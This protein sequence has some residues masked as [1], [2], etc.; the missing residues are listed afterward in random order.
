MTRLVP[1]VL[2]VLAWPASAQ[3]V[4]PV[5][6]AAPKETAAPAARP[7]PEEREEA[8]APEAEAGSAADAGA[9]DGGPTD[10]GPTDTGPTD[11]LTERPPLPTELAETPEDYRACLAALD[12]FG[13]EYAEREAIEGAERDCGIANPVG[14][15]SIVPGV[16]L[17]PDAVMRCETALALAQWV[18]GTVVPAARLAG[19]L[20]PLEAVDHGSTYV[21]RRR[22]GVAAGKLSEHALGNAVDVMGFRFADGTALSVEPRADSGTIEEAFQRAVRGGACLSFTTVLGPGTDAAHADHLHLDVKKRRAGYRIC[23]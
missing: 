13:T 7:D 4:T 5:G 12:E 19:T 22:G 6:E 2:I 20:A 23:Q 9:T 18:S 3:D 8:F 11:A 17:R 10:T 1:A 15:A 21:C 16:A 14:V